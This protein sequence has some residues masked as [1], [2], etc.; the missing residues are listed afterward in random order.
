MPIVYDVETTKTVITESAKQFLCTYEEHLADI[1]DE[2]AQGG[3]IIDLVSVIQWTNELHGRENDGYHS[4]SP[5]EDAALIAVLA[6][7]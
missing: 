3:G 7:L 4:T 1:R 2:I 5:A 6:R